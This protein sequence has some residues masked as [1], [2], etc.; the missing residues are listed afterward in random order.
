VLGRIGGEVGQEAQVE[1]DAA[2]RQVEQVLQGQSAVAQVV[3]RDGDAGVVQG[4]ELAAIEFADEL[5]F[6]DFDLQQSRP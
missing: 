2:D 3:D 1:L 4:D 6:G 5:R